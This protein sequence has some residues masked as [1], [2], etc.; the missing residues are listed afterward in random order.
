MPPLDP[1]KDFAG[2]D[3]LDVRVRSL[4]AVEPFYDRFL[5]LVGL[6]GKNEAHVDAA[7]EW[8]E[9][10]PG[11]PRNAIEY[12]EE[13]A[14]GRIRHFIGFIENPQ[15]TVSETRVAFRVSPERL[16]A[17]GEEL[18]AIGACDVDPSGSE[19][20]KAIF[21]N[22]PAGTRLEICARHPSS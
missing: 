8:H 12:Y 15:M 17:L 22:D 4:A 19:E 6:F 1:V 16:G 21:F 9:V 7:G 20:Y 10:S 5:P 11:H 2:F 3:H 13:A 14:P 18:A